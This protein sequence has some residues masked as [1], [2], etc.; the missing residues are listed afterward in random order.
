[1]EHS[2]IV[3][4]GSYLPTRILTNADLENLV[5]TTEEWIKSRSGIEARHIAAVDET[6][7]DMGYLAAQR[8]LDAAQLSPDKI[9]LIIV[10]TCTPDKMFPSTA[11]LIQAKLKCKR[12]R[13]YDHGQLSRSGNGRRHR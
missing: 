8:A 3:G 12:G 2:S 9:D 4:T 1:M 10:A 5:D 11:C 13:N 6:S 7:A